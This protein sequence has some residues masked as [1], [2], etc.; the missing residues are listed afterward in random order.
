ME[1]P[2]APHGLIDGRFRFAGNAALSPYGMIVSTYFVPERDAPL[3]ESPDRPPD[4]TSDGRCIVVNGRR[5]RSSDPNIPEPLRKELVAELLN[6][7]REVKRVKDSPELLAVVRSRV[8][9]A[10]VALGERG[11]AWW[12]PP[13]E[14]GRSERLRAAILALLIK[15]GDD[16]SI[17]PSDAARI[18]ASPDWRSAMDAARAE[19]IDLAQEGRIRITQGDVVVADPTSTVGPIRYRL[20][21]SDGA[22]TVK[23]SGTRRSG[24]RS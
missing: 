18:A 6:A 5:W 20:P 11:E 2:H 17:C 21:V 13:T 22:A 23:Q 1:A 12:A 3:T 24:R 16:S 10:K 8:H 19:G 9:D 15:R 4:R 7:R 14:K